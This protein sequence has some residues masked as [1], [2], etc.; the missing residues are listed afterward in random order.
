MTLTIIISIITSILLILSILFF[1]R[2]KIGKFAIGTYWV[3]ALVGAIMMIVTNRVSISSIIDGLLTKT[4]INPLKILCLFIS[5]TILS[6]FLDEVG[7]FKHMANIVCMKAK[8]SQFK[9]F[10]YLYILTSILTVFTS[11]DIIILTFTPFICYFAKNTKINPIPYLIGEFVAANTWSMMLV[12]GNPTNIY[13]AQSFN[14]GFLD[15]FLVMALPTL[16]SGFVAF[17]LLYL[18]FRKYLKEEIVVSSYEEIHENKF[19]LITGLIHLGLCTILLAISNYIGLE[20][21]YITLGFA[22]SLLTIITIYKIIHHEKDTEVEETIIRAPWTLIPFVLS[23]FVIV[24]ALKEN[25]LTKILGEFFGNNYL[26]IKYGVSSFI[27]ANI[28]NNIPMSLFFTEI[29][30][31][32]EAINKGAIFASIVGSNIG[33]FLT[34]IGA[35]AGIMWMS[36]LKRQG[37]EMSFFS[38]TKYGVIIGVP[39]ILSCLGVLYLI[40]L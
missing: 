13:L 8:K 31:S 40:L 33:A 9:L 30:N 15:Y 10:L 2:I 34:P 35:L 11:N 3:I 14:I 5:M 24:L 21:W 28:I 36:I 26:V 4:S 16:V 39:T 18:V 38:F 20:M 22:I 27:S 32:V 29:I 6:I 17:V 1:P 7:F 19:L 25:G 37:V 23:M 12:I